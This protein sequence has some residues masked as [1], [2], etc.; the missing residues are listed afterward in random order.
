MSS[1]SQVAP[2]FN[3]SKEDPLFVLEKSN[4]LHSGEIVVGCSWTTK[5]SREVDIDVSLIAFDAAGAE[6]GVAYFG[7]SGTRM[8]GSSVYHHGDD[9]T[10]AN[11]RTVQ[12]NEQISVNLDVVPAN[13]KSL[14]LVGNVYDGR[15]HLVKTWTMCLRDKNGD[16]FLSMDASK[17]KSRGVIFCAL[18]RSGENWEVRLMNAKGD[19]AGYAG[20]MRFINARDLTCAGSAAFRESTSNN[21]SFFKQIFWFIKSF[22]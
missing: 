6:A 18:V 5:F 11:R 22:F 7:N 8:V 20:N 2:V 16:S 14:F 13:V 1:S 10:G 21:D 17:L 3:L 19:G 9:L 12:D 4:P 15:T